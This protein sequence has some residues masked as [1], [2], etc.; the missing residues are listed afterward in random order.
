MVQDEHIETKRLDDVE[1]K[2]SILSFLLAVI[3]KK[4]RQKKRIED[5]SCFETSKLKSL[6]IHYVSLMY[7]YVISVI[8]ITKGNRRS[9]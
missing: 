7:S 4:P 5:M 3:D 6:Y 8:Q 2:E 9:L 1:P